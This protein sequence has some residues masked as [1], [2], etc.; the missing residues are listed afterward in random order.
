MQTTDMGARKIFSG[1]NSSSNSSN[2]S[3][4]NSNVPSRRCFSHRSLHRPQC[5]RTRRI[6]LNPFQDLY[7]L[8]F[9]KQRRFHSNLLL[10]FK[11]CMVN[12]L[13]SLDGN[14]SLSSNVLTSLL[15]TRHHSS[16]YT[17]RP[18]SIFHLPKDKSLMGQAR[19]IAAPSHFHPLRSSSHLRRRRLP[20]RAQRCSSSS[21]SSIVRWLQAA[22]HLAVGEGQVGVLWAAAVGR[23]IAVEIAVVGGT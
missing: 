10:L 20:S 8:I 12:N 22:S 23:V 14:F 4:S 3:N 1:S 15:T 17:I 21:S 2:S 7:S 18:L 16:N 11:I 9:P 5:N 6:S 19:I 13:N